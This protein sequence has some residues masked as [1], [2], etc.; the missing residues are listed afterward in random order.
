[1]SDPQAWAEDLFQL[2]DRFDADAVAARMAHDGALIIVNND[3]VVGRDGMRD[4]VHRFEQ[5][6]AR[7]RHEVL[8]AW[9]ADETVI[10]Q[11]RVAYV[12]HDGRKVVLPCTNI[13]DLTE[14]GLISRYQIFMDMTPVFA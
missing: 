9:Q 12:R 10:T 11:L 2:L 6:V 8:R 7:I 5:G 14:D 1:M 13:F 4:A 3:P